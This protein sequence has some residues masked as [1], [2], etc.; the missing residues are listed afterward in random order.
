MPPAVAYYRV[1]TER[2]RRSGL[3]I[4]AQQAAVVRFAQTAG[5]NL[6]TEFVD[7]ASGK[8]ADALERGHSSPGRSRR[9]APSA[10]R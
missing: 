3:G 9:P 4:E 8:G 10:A 7:A 2:Q 5:F 1:S 6:I